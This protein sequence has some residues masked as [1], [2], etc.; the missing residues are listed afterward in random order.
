MTHKTLAERL[1]DAANWTGI[2]RLA[3]LVEKQR[4]SLRWLPILPLLLA[5]TGVVLCFA[6]TSRFWPGYIVVIAGFSLSIWMPMFGPLKPWGVI[7]NADERE[8]D[9]RRR[10]FLVTLWVVAMLGVISL[11]MVPAIA[12]ILGWTTDQLMRVMMALG[13]ALFTTFNALPTLYASWATHPLP[14]ED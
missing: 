1:D 10:A 4:R 5:I 7:G 9:L 13:M 8:R 12:E 6:D 3:G 2:P 11:L 14:D